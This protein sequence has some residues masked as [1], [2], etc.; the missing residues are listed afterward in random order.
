M[1]AAWLGRPLRIL[2]CTL[3]GQRLA[4][5]LETARKQVTKQS[6]CDNKVKMKA[7]FEVSLGS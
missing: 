1:A 3:S 7:H 6:R 2:C 4:G 5:H